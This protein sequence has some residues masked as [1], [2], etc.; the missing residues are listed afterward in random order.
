M[1]SEVQ[2]CQNSA[3]NYTCNCIDGYFLSGGTCQDHD[4]CYFK[5]LTCPEKSTCENTPGSYKCNCLTGFVGINCY[6][7]DECL[8]GD[9]NC[10][11]HAEC[12]NI[13]GSFTCACKKG[14][15][16][17]GQY[18]TAG[19]CLDS[20]CPDNEQCVSPTRTDCKCKSGFVRNSTNFCTDVDECST[21]NVCDE[22]ADCSNTLGSYNCSCE[23]G[24]VGDGKFCSEG[25]CYDG[26]F[27][28]ENE[29]RYSRLRFP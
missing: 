23:M 17:N 21:E 11:G 8:N 16:G 15:Y 6:D 18:C 26:D 25:N 1:C 3:G 7:S 19:K 12:K 28:S 2:K 9:H 20:S 4:E 24:F 14:Y 29:V 27:C 5:N 22:K 13:E 10:H